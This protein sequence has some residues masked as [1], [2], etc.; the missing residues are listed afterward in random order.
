MASVSGAFPAATGGAMAIQANPLVA[1]SP[2]WR[3]ALLTYFIV[4]EILPQPLSMVIHGSS[5]PHA[6][7][8]MMVNMALWFVWMAPLLFPR[9]AGIPSGWLHPFLLPMLLSEARSVLKDPSALLAPVVVWFQPLPEFVDHPQLFGWPVDGI[10]AAMLKRDALYLLAALSTL[11]GFI[12]LRWRVSVHPTL[13]PRRLS[14]VMTALFALFFAAFALF[15]YLQGGIARYFESFSS[16]RYLV[17]VDVGYI[18]GIFSAT[19]AVLTIWYAADRK[20]VRNP[21]FWVA[22]AMTCAMQFAATGTRSGA[23]YPLMTLGVLYL[24]HYRRPPLVLALMTGLLA[25]IAVG[26]LGQIRSSVLQGSDT[27]GQFSLSSITE[28]DLEASLERTRTEIA[29]RSYS[30]PAL[31]TIALVPEHADYLWGETYLGALLFFVPRAIWESKPRGVG[32]YSQA[33]IMEK[34]AYQ[35][36]EYTGAGASPG[37]V[38]EAYWNFDVFGVVVVFALFGGVLSWAVRTYM[39]NHSSFAVFALYLTLLTDVTGPGSSDYAMFMQ[40][41]C[42]MLGL[43]WVL[44]VF[45]GRRGRPR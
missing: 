31:P 4:W 2:G 22:T 43:F 11:T 19:P 41:I 36:G 17:R 9:I 28:F 34:N 23:I 29:S 39:L 27:R 18:L 25:L 6:L 16:G 12:V 32:A 20:V 21:I 10:W 26:V 37:N 13:Q 38:A 5:N 3:V 24:W 8:S 33:I 1:F 35:E 45:R 40:R 14:W 30:S 42:L 15:L 7:A 44:G